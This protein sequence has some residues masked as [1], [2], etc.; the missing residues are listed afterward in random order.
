[1]ALNVVDTNTVDT[2]MVE[3][4]TI[5]ENNNNQR[6]INRE[7]RQNTWPLTTEVYLFN[8]VLHILYFDE[9]NIDNKPVG[10]SVSIEP[11]EDP[12]IYFTE[13]YTTNHT[14]SL[15]NLVYYGRNNDEVNI[16]RTYILNRSN[17]ARNILTSIIN[18]YMI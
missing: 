7:R 12:Y 15:N 6:I 10:I 3:T 1:M 17:D 18:S 14:R 11:F 5:N 2:N 13:G 8:N 16:M 9:R 4:I